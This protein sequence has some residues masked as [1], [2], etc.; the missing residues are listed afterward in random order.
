MPLQK[1]CGGQIGEQPR[2]GKLSFHS[3]QVRNT[4]GLTEVRGERAGEEG[5]AKVYIKA[6]E[7]MGS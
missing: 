7:P 5:R 4:E 2:E 1:L 3:G 6:E